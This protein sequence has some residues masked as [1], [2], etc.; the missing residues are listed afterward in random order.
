MQSKGLIKFLVVV[1]TLA[2]LYSLSFTFVTR[3]V[4]KDAATYAGGDV[5]KER[6]Y[7]DSIAGETV[8]NLG[9]AKYT[10]REAK[11]NE[12]AL[13]LDLK[14]GM[15]V[16]MEIAL[17]ELISNLAN[18]PEDEKFQNALEEAIKKTKSTNKT[19]V[20]LF[21]EEYNASN[22]STPLAS[23]FATSENASLIKATSNT[24]QVRSFLNRE[25][26]SAI[27]NAFKVLRTRIDKFGVSSPNIQIQQGTNRI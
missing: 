26:E 21:I 24:S 14:G 22:A 19:L 1:I 4:E 10:Y 17:D 3:K 25:A 6:A 2:C 12:L 13:G 9:I 8:F 20:D 11:A 5:D 27:E 23:F 7:L 16:T 18:N 15:N